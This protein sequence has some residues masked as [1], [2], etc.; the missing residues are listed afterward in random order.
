M[1]DESMKK[2]N[3]EQLIFVAGGSFETTINGIKE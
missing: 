3:T 2:I 1:T